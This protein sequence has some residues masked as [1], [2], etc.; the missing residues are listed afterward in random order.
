MPTRKRST[1]VKFTSFQ[2]RRAKSFRPNPAV[3][4]A[5]E[6]VTGNEYLLTWGRMRFS[7]FKRRG[8]HE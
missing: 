8:S 2:R 7:V 5:I 6:S 4:L 1:Q 3:A